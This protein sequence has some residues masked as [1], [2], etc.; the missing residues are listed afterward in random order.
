MNELSK[1]KDENHNIIKKYII[2]NQWFQIIK[3]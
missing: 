1:Q 3:Q 2:S